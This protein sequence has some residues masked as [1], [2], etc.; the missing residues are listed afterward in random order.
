M[1]AGGSAVALFIFMFFPWYGVPGTT[2]QIPGGG[3]ISSSGEN[4]NAWQVFSWIDVIM[5]LVI[6][7]TIAMVLARVAG[8]MPPEL[9]APPGLIVAVAGAL[10]TLLI[11]YRLLNV[12]GPDGSDVGRKIGAFLGLLAAGGVAFGG[13]TAS[14]E[15]A[16]G[17]A[18]P[19]DASAPPP[20][21]PTAPPP[22]GP[23]AQ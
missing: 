7:L 3:S 18:P 19:A 4:A 9:P 1:I 10:V 20:P 22:T 6:L 11:F 16:S 13:Y 8:A 12:P 5:F 23:P 17:Q 2:I 14:T 21:P 15:R